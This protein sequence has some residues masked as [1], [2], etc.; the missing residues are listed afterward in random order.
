MIVERDL[1]ER[2]EQRDARVV[3]EKSN[4]VPFRPA[5]GLVLQVRFR[6]I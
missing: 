6:E 4:L 5:S 2:I 3:H 1:E